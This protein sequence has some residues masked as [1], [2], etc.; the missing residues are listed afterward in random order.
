M[1]VGILERLL[2]SKMDEKSREEEKITG[3][4]ATSL[5]MTKH[6]SAAEA[7]RSSGTVRDRLR[8]FG[9]GL[10][11]CFE[12]EPNEE[13]EE[14]AEGEEGTV[15]R[16]SIPIW[17]DREDEEQEPSGDETE[18]SDDKQGVLQK[19]AANIGQVFVMEEGAA[20]D[21]EGEEARTLIGK[22]M[23]EDNEDGEEEDEVKGHDKNQRVDLREHAEIRIE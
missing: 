22:W 21:E 1:R 18:R 23:A 15:R 14:G 8:K 9:G 16:A 5:P 6:T 20:D 17:S 2:R 3:S 10:D 4:K 13:L 7:Y 11:G 12:I 19:K